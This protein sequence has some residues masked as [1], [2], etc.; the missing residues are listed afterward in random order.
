MILLAAA[1]SSGGALIWLGGAVSASVL[2]GAVMKIGRWYGS[3]EERLTR[4]DEALS[5]LGTA[6]ADDEQE[7]DPR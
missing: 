4:H 1:A 7:D 5:R 2:I 3:V 6:V